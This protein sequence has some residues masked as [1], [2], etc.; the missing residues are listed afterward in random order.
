MVPLFRA[1]VKFFGFFF[2]QVS[3]SSLR[4]LK[5]CELTDTL[6]QN[7]CNQK[8]ISQSDYESPSGR[9]MKLLKSTKTIATIHVFL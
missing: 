5:M 4:Q 9:K 7:I 8:R 6:N 3:S 2:P 1:V